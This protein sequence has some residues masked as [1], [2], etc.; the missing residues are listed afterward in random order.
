MSQFRLEIESFTPPSLPDYIGV[1][2]SAIKPL[3]GNVTSPTSPMTFTISLGSRGLY[4][5]T[6]LQLCYVFE[7]TGSVFPP[8]FITAED[9]VKTGD[10]YEV[11]VL[12]KSI[13]RSKVNEGESSTGKVMVYAWK[14]E[15]LLGS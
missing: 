15:I 6:H 11:T 7:G 5:A 4:P 2:V 13:P 10:Y 8:E 1:P 12:P 9:L 14:W 3:Y